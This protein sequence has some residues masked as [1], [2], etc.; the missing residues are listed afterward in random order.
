MNVPVFEQGR[1]DVASRADQ[2]GVPDGITFEQKI[3]RLV[4]LAIARCGSAAALARE[5]KVKPPT[6]S[7]WR[8]GRKRPAAV[9]LIHIQELV[10]KS[11][12]LPPRDKEH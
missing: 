7:Q 2:V 6:V 4:E 11:D 12:L 3:Q 1:G 8:A 10:A 5:L 9:K